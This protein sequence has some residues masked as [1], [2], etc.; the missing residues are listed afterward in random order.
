ML[1]VFSGSSESGGEGGKGLIGGKATTKLDVGQ[2]SRR[3][4][5]NFPRQLSQ[6]KVTSLS[7]FPDAFSKALRHV[8]SL[9]RLTPFVNS[10]DKTTPGVQSI[11]GL[12]CIYTHRSLV[13][14]SCGH[15]VI[16]ASTTGF[17]LYAASVVTG[18]SIWSKKTLANIQ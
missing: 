2:E 1:K 11:H 6:G 7:Q 4:I 3:N 18:G 10:S 8:V 15:Q 12:P 13:F 17:R 14:R 5:P 9:R 16:N